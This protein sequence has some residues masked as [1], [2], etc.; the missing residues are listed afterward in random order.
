MNV[1]GIK[2]GKDVE[3]SVLYDRSVTC[4]R[5]VDLRRRFDVATIDLRAGARPAGTRADVLLAGPSSR[6]SR[7]SRVRATLQRVYKAPG[8]T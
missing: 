6:H 1:F 7:V 2:R 4:G 8:A 5:T 3:K